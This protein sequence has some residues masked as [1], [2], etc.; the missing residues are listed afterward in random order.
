MSKNSDFYLVPVVFR[1]CIGLLLGS[2]SLGSFSLAAQATQL[3]PHQLDLFAVQLTH[4]DNN[5]QNSYRFDTTV[6]NTVLNNLAFSRTSLP[7]I[8]E[9]KKDTFWITSIHWH[10]TD[11]D[12]LASLS[13]Q[14]RLE[15]KKSFIEIR[16][17]QRSV[18]MTWRFE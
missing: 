13:P 3:E 16:P 2:L 6:A 18:W 14:F 1:A 12:N 15:S 5:Q 11:D 4:T 9:F 10:L 7:T 17:I 8:S